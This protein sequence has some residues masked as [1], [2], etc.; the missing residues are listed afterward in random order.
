MEGETSD[1]IE[2]SLMLGRAEMAVLEHDLEFLAF[3]NPNPPICF[4]E[5]VTRYKV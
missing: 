3:V 2:A 5:G 1:K 4:V